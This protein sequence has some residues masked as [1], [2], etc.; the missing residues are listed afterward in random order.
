MV[1]STDGW[2]RLKEVFASARA[3][4]VDLRAAYLAK[5]CGSDDALR[6]EVESLLAIGPARE[7]FSRST[8]G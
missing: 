2:P 1:L 8:R 7:E 4:P 5:A 3:L 6:G